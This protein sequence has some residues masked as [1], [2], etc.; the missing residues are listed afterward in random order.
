[1]GLRFGKNQIVYELENHSL[2]AEVH[3][4]T[5]NDKILISD[6]DGTLTKSD[7]GGLIGNTLKV[8]YLHE[9][10]AEMIRKVS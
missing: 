4:F 2:K 3:L 7:L 10:Y 1:M 9:G 8:D 5:D 6:F